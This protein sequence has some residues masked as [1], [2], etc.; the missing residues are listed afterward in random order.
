MAQ[1]ERTL[2]QMNSAQLRTI[3]EQ[4]DRIKELE[5][6]EKF[7]THLINNCIDQ[8][9]TLENLEKWLLESK[10]PKRL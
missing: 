10:T 3:V 2:E 1:T 4:T 8:V 6:W 9:V 7:A 5:Q